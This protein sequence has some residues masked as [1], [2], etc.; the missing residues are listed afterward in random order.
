MQLFAKNL[1]Q[2][3]DLQTIALPLRNLGRHV[4]RWSN[5]NSRL[6][7]RRNIG[8]HYDLSNEMFALF[9]DPTMTYSSAV[10]ADE[11][12][13]LEEASL[14][15]YELIC[16]KLHLR[17]EDHVVEIGCGWGGFAEYAAYN[18]GCRVTGIT[19][20]SEQL[21][22]AQQRIARAGLEKRVEL[23]LCDYRDMDGTFDKLV[24][25][26]MI[27]AVGH[28]Y[29]ATFFRKCDALLRPDG[30]MLLQ[31]I[32]I[33]DDRYDFYRRSVDFIQKYIFP[34][35]CLPCLG[36]ISNIVARETDMRIVHLEDFAG[37]YAQTLLH[38]RE[39]FL[40]SRV[41]LHQLGFDETFQR[42]WDYYFCYC[43]AGFLERQI[44]LAHVLLKRPEAR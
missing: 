24:S 3:N 11:N 14:S 43:I 25:I 29:L 34:G 31:A 27:E 21:D 32:T 8:R 2:R 13:T 22:F 42:T 19:I 20:S 36:G 5:R 41:E 7:S 12:A 17:A 28:E 10:F 6:G 16:Q 15:K 39:N 9:L 30:E 35:G 44:G 1:T 33:P 37:S 18:Y 38:W 26:E 40:A 23:R 4:L